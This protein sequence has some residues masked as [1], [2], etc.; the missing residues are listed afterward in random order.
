[1]L[2]VQLATIPG[3]IPRSVELT[4]ETV[5]GIASTQAGSLLEGPMPMPE[6][7][8]TAILD[9][10]VP[11]TFTLRL[12]LQYGAE[13]AGVVLGPL[14]DHDTL[15]LVGGRAPA[16]SPTAAA[17]VSYVGTVMHH[18]KRPNDDCGVRCDDGKLQIDE[19]CATCTKNGISVKVCC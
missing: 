9:V 15:A 13:R 14:H 4:L 5:D 18:A 17:R 10:D 3:T 8:T 16:T 11:P 6:P 1:V 19:C 7:G 12:V 2:H